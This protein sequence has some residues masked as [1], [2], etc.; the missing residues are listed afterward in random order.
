[1]KWRLHRLVVRPSPSPSLR[2][3]GVGL[4][5][6]A[7]LWTSPVFAAPPKMDW[8]LPSGVGLASTT[9]ITASDGAGWPVKVWIDDPQGVTVE[10]HKD[11]GKFTVTTAA[12]AAPG[13]RWVRLHN[14]EGASALR[15]LIVG[16]LPEVAEKEPN[17]AVSQAQEVAEKVVVN[18]RL[19]KSGEVD[20][21]KV[22]L[23]GGQTLVASMMANHVLASPMDA[24]I[25]VCDAS[26]FVL[27]Q[28]HDTHGLDPQVAFLAPRD[29][30]FIVRT[31]AFPAQP[32][33]TINYAGGPAYIYRLTLTTGGFVDHALPLAMSAGKPGE[34]ALYGWNLPGEA[35]KLTLS[36]EVG[37]E[38]VVVRHPLLG[39]TMEV[40]VMPGA[41]VVAG[42]S[43]GSAEAQAVSLPAVISG[44]IAA[45][46][47]ARG[48]AFRFPGKKGQALRLG[49]E[50]ASLGF[51]VDPVVRIVDAAGKQI[52][53]A[54]DAKGLAQR[55]PMINFNPPADGDYIVC[56]RDLTGRGGFR[57]VY[58]LTIAPP[59]AEFAVTLE[60]D[61]FSGA[62][63]K[64]IEFPVTIDRRDGFEGEITVRVEGLPEGAEAQAVV[65]KPKDATAKAVK[66][67][68]TPKTGPWSGP[69]RIVAESAG[70]KRRATFGV[71][72]G[73]RHEQAWLTVTK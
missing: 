4:A 57:F 41:V 8:L 58:R 55:D 23:K 70:I 10:A 65:S 50:S 72:G 11:A 26:G 64:A 62:A 68:I 3:R 13:V 30:E 73:A 6:A 39:N 38:R 52:S 47:G 14:A 29:G 7:L 17:N 40:G 16:T 28:N 53:E 31:F 46:H 25:Q 51:A 60:K 24:V 20:A 45:E 33:S 66:V 2:G 35:A 63:N 22:R 67:I 49:V 12:D 37:A 44:R 9:I 19:E 15:P 32:D 56:V 27:M 42:D 5:I 59:T 54:D 36:P 71:T 18:G 61:V 69:I 48:H 34:V 21:F 1:M 43:A